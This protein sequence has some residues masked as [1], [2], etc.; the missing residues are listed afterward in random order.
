MT[1]AL[2]VS[3]S[4]ESHAQDL[5]REP[6]PELVRRLNIVTDNGTSRP[7]RT[8]DVYEASLRVNV[9]WVTPLGELTVSMS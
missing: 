6:T 8:L 2:S 9:R 7:T 5:A 3:D 4:G 1:S